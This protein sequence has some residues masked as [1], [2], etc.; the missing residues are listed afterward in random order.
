MIE[1][2]RICKLKLVLHVGVVPHACTE[3]IENDQWKWQGYSILTESWSSWDFSQ[4][5]NGILQC[6]LQAQSLYIFSFSLEPLEARTRD[7]TLNYSLTHEVVIPGSLRGNHEESEEAI[8]Q[9]H[10]NLL[11]V[12]WQVTFRVIAF[13]CVLSTP[14]VPTRRQLIR[15]QGAWTW[16]ETEMQSRYKFPVNLYPHSCYCRKGWPDLFYF[17]I[18]LWDGINNSRPITLRSPPIIE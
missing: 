17:K 7:Q 16:R 4:P 5:F 11:V 14:V 3:K 13:V 2:L 6:N 1:L 8:R 18:T 12:R 10:L 15:R 9:Q